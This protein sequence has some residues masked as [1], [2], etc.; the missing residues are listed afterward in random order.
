MT[1][2]PTPTETPSC[3]PDFD[4]V[5]DGVINHL[6]VLEL[7]RLSQ[8]GETPDLNCDGKA[9][10]ADLWSMGNVWEGTLPQ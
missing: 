4:L 6:D 2:T 1:A 8:I 5:V 9:D 3:I 7:I 10:F